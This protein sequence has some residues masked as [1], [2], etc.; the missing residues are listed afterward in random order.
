[1][2]VSVAAV[3]RKTFVAVV[4]AWLWAVFVLQAIYAEQMPALIATN[5]CVSSGLALA[6]AH[7]P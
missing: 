5:A 1:M 7:S 3:L 6:A 4:L 2:T